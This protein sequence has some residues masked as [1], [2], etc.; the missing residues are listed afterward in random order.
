MPLKD[1]ATDLQQ[2]LQQKS[3]SVAKRLRRKIQDQIGPG[4]LVKERSGRLKKAIKLRQVSQN[5]WQ[6]YVDE[7]EVPYAKFVVLGTRRMV[8]RDFLTKGVQELRS[9]LAEE[10]F[11]AI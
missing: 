6:V 5:K 1:F 7:N 9:E 2:R 3:K 10:G 8:A 4:K 11:K